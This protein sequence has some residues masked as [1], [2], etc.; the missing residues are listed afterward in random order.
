MTL[1]QRALAELENLFTS[2]ILSES[3]RLKKPN[4]N[5]EVWESIRLRV[6]DFCNRHGCVDSFHEICCAID[7]IMERRADAANRDDS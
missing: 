7:E 3:I 2:W 5:L 4:T 6:R 1:Y